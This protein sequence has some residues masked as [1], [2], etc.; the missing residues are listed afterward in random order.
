MLHLSDRQVPQKPSS[1]FTVTQSDQITLFAQK[2]KTK[3]V[4]EVKSVSSGTS[5]K[6]T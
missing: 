2:K 4:L 1:V 5:D 3:N 6:V